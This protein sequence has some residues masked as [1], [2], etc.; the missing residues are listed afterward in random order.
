MERSLSQRIRETDE[1]SEELQNEQR[2]IEYRLTELKVEPLNLLGSQNQLRHRL[3][4]LKQELYENFR[5]YTET[6]PVKI[7]ADNEEF[8]GLFAGDQWR[9]N[10]SFLKKKSELLKNLEIHLLEERFKMEIV[11]NYLK[12]EYEVVK[13]KKIELAEASGRYAM[14]EEYEVQLQR[15]SE[16]L[17]KKR[18]DFEQQKRVAMK[19]Q[20]IFTE[21]LR[22]IHSL[23]S[24]TVTLPLQLTVSAIYQQLSVL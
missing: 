8:H 10:S 16:L 23:G 24:S 5:N 17:E 3:A 14:M 12:K 9:E 13:V 18:Q 4:S 11:E 6:L 22:I 2:E 19:T 7:T 15:E 21:Y 1:L 20:H